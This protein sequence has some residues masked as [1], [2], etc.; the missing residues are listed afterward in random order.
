MR[1][2]T[3]FSVS[4]LSKLAGVSVR[5][6]HHYDQVGL[7]KPHRR[8]AN[9]YRDYTYD[10]LITLQQIIIYR[11]LDFSINDIQQLLNAEDFDLLSA[12][13]SQKTLL[14]ERQ[15]KTNAMINS[16]EATMTN[17]QGKRNVDIIF[18]DLPKEKL[19][20]WDN[21][22]KD[23]LGISFSS[24]VQRVSG[25]LSED[26]ARCLKEE[27]EALAKE[28]VDHINF[29]IESREIQ[30]LVRRFIQLSSS[31]MQGAS[32]GVMDYEKTIFSA[33]KMMND[34]LSQE[35]Y[36][37]YHQDFAHHLGRAMLYFAEHNLK[38]SL[39]RA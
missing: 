3:T 20:L 5:T 36:S 32:M 37:I 12:L 38:G 16:I 22:S 9:G 39:E 18:E 19:E 30:D 34:P 8:L 17:I 14:L 4:E 33:E 28:Y 13:E 2:N 10:H 7:L 35:I 24:V 1:K 27:N 25:N 29:P 6:L 31:M 26:Q 15:K 11:E 21:L 23:A